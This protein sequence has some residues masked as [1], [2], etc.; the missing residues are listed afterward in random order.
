[1]KR[2]LSILLALFMLMSVLLVSCGKDDS[3]NN[4]TEN[5]NTV[6]TSDE[7]DGI[8][9]E[10]DYGGTEVK[11]LVRDHVSRY[12]DWYNG[13]NVEGDLTALQQ[14]V[15]ERN[16]AVEGNLGVKLKFIQSET[17][18]NGATINN[19]IVNAF[20]GGLGDY[21]IVSNYQHFGT[22][23]TL[24]DCYMNLYNEQF[25]YFNFDHPYWNQNFI[26]GAEAF[27]RL[28]LVVGDMNLAVYKTAFTMYFNK[29]LCEAHGIKDTDLYGLVLDNK[30]TIEKLMEYTKN[31]QSIVDE[32]DY[33]ANTYG[34]DTI[35]ESHAYDG[36]V[37]AFD[38]DLTATDSDGMHSLVSDS[39]LQKL[40]D[41]ADLIAN[42][43]S[44]PE[45]ILRKSLSTNPES[46]FAK[47]NALFGL[48][49][50]GEAS[51][52]KDT[53]EDEYGMLPMPKYTEDQTEYYGGV[54]DSHDAVSVIAHS[55]N[56]EH[57]EMISAVLE[58]MNSVSYTTVR[59]Y[60]IETLVKFRY[61]QDMESGQVIDIILKGTRWDF[62][63]IYA[64]STGEIRN[65]LWRVPLQKGD[66]I[67][68]KVG[69]QKDTVN[70]L[71]ETL[72]TWLV[73]HY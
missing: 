50:I 17:G 55:D 26:E 14:K 47:G 59:P 46:V 43:Y 62:S 35:Y 23:P 34:L 48:F 66:Q 30:W 2:T 44:R 28:F 40:Y 69:G 21:D 12:G 27:D 24:L 25:K 53:M 6:D 71:L 9:D 19:A 36:W 15:Y 38:C 72:D 3:G 70:A 16:V 20:M 4:V 67:S 52:F 5:N 10:L 58:K 13:E 7:G 18:F 8:P 61:A 42:Y 51:G 73:E 60:F 64:V 37:A 32:N 22:S 57:Y 45:V 65:N 1:M 56:A 33:L 63:D 31:T 68:S 39:A 11:I 29:T 54:Q 41:A 49:A